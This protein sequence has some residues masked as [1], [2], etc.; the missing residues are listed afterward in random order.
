MTSRARSWIAILVALSLLGIP[1]CAGPKR[2]PDVDFKLT[3]TAYMEDG[4]LIA[5][6]VSVR[7]ALQREDRPYV[8]FQIAIMNK[9]LKGITINR[10]FFELV[11]EDGNRYA[12]VGFDELK[13]S[14]GNID[15]DRR[16]GDLDGV[17]EGKYQSYVREP[18]TLT[19]SF[20]RPTLLVTKL[21]RF[22]Y[23]IDWL[24]FPMPEGGIKERRFELF[25]NAPELPDPV[26]V[27]FRVTG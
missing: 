8:P 21:P 13:N 14:Y 6:V 16:L 19:E 9:G 26:F 24:Y 10:E 22:A 2:D 20:D 17:I 12:P 18:S 1:G 23:I 25:L 11:D 5:F 27:K 4:D 15:L 3:N 7:A